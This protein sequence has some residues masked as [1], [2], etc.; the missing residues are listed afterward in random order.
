M[1]RCRAFDLRTVVLLVLV[2]CFELVPAP[3]DAADGLP[4]CDVAGDQDAVTVALAT[5]GS[6]WVVWRD[7]R[8]GP[9]FSDVY[10]ARLLVI[11]PAR[12]GSTTSPASAG[13]A[14]PLADGFV[15]CASGTAGPPFAVPADSGDVLLLWADSR[16][17]RGIYAQRLRSDGSVY[18]GWPA[19]GRLVTTD[20]SDLSLAACT[21][22]EGGAYFLRRPPG[23]P[24]LQLV[25]LTRITGTG[26]FASGW[27]EAGVVVGGDEQVQGFTLAPD[28]SGGAVFTV[29]TYFN[30]MAA[31]LQIGTAGRVSPTGAVVSRN[32][33][34]WRSGNFAP[35]IVGS[36]AFADGLGGFV[37]AWNDAPA[38]EFYAQRWDAAGIKQWPDSLVSPHMDFLV[39]DGLGGMYLVGREKQDLNRL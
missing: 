8:R 24:E 3:V 26:A 21:D 36:V 13:T 6:S 15:A 22:G 19:D 37:A 38:P 25:R 23:S 5:D 2:S 28:A 31:D 12:T 16:V 33:P 7:R 4:V 27:T 34:G 32:L 11:I 29:R 14:T 20:V 9:S 18:P 30:G 1:V 17:P 10:A 35:G 39:A